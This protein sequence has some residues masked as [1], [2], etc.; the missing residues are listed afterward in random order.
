MNLKGT[1]KIKKNAKEIR[2]K[3]DDVNELIAPYQLAWINAKKDIEL[4]AINAHYMEDDTF[5]NLV[6][7]IKE[8]GFL[9]QLPFGVKQDNG[10]YLIVS[11]N[12]RV[13]ASIQ[14]GEN[15]ML[16]LFVEGIDD[17]KKMAYQLSHNK[18]VG[19]D[20]KKVLREL[21]AKIDSVKNQDFSGL[22]KMKFPELKIGRDIKADEKDIKLH[23]VKF[24]FTSAQAEEVLELMDKIEGMKLNKDLTRIVNIDFKQFDTFLSEFKERSEI[25]SNTKAFL[26]LIELAEQTEKAAE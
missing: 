1:G 18:L 11:G 12:H 21:Y 17:D 19:K 8:D 7:N 22:S 16:I 6:Q 4:L 5:E 26:K 9:S 3:L 10:K 2:G 25:K 23:E 13:K 14:A 24:L 20:N 15:E